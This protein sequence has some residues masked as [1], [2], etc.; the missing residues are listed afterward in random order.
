MLWSSAALGAIGANIALCKHCLGIWLQ[1]LERAHGLN[2]AILEAFY[3]RA[4]A[5][6]PAALATGASSAG[7][8][9]SGVEVVEHWART[10]E[11]FGALSHGLPSLVAEYAADMCL[12][13]QSPTEKRCPATTESV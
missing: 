1:T 13:P 4:I 10:S 6:A 12:I 9:I 11:I 8:A 3:V 2:V 5:A 7:R